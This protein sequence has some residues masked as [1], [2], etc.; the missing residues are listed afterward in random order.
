MIVLVLYTKFKHPSK[1]EALAPC[2]ANAGPPSTTSAQ[3]QANV[4]CSLGHHI[5]LVD[6]PRSQVGISPRWRLFGNIGEC[7][8]LEIAQIIRCCFPQIFTN[9]CRLFAWFANVRQLHAT[10]AIFSPNSSQSPMRRLIAYL[11][12]F[13]AEFSNYSSIP[14]IFC[15]FCLLLEYC[16]PNVPQ[17][18]VKLWQISPNVYFAARKISGSPNGRQNFEHSG[19]HQS[20][21]V[22]HGEHSSIY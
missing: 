13:I 9:L 22:E 18:V 3:H 2:W 10:F 19:E 7:Q 5:F 20:T 17:I 1:Y 16:P 4:P 12:L 21:L 14:S 11:R 8:I 6:P 15:F